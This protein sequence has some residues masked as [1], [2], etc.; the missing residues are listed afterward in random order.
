MPLNLASANLPPVEVSLHLPSH[1]FPHLGAKLNVLI[2]HHWVKELQTVRNK[3]AHASSRDVPSGEIYRDA[4]TLGRVLGIIGGSAEA[5]ASVEEV[6]TAAVKQLAAQS[7]PRPVESPP[8]PFVWPVPEQAPRK[9]PVIELLEAVTDERC[10]RVFHNNAKATYFE[11]QL[12]AMAAPAENQTQLTAEEIHASVTSLQLH[13]DGWSTS[14]TLLTG[15]ASGWRMARSVFEGDSSI[16]P[17]RQGIDLRS[18][19][20]E[21]E[22][23]GTDQTRPAT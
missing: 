2:S 13:G 18:R 20:A 21:Q 22:A 10:Y 14:K 23:P 16:F 8:V 5:I 17:L 9:E 3:W 6:K 7:L 4:D 1:L 11:S 15:D 12:Q 19:Q